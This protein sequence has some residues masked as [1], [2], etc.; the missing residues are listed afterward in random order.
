MHPRP[1]PAQTAPGRTLSS[2]RCAVAAAMTDATGIGQGAATPAPPS[3]KQPRRHRQWDAHAEGLAGKLI[4]DRHRAAQH[5]GAGECERCAK[6]RTI[7]IRPHAAHPASACQ[8][9]LDPRTTGGDLKGRNSI[10]IGG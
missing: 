9:D 5:G 3:D 7:R 1:I 4:A 2:R 10:L 8:L 6:Q